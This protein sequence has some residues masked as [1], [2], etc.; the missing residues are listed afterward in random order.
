M[1]A[2]GVTM[3]ETVV[4]VVAMADVEEVVVMEE[5]EVADGDCLYWATKGEGR[6]SQT[7]RGLGVFGAIPT[8]GMTARRWDWLFDVYIFPPLTIE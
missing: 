2:E 8:R 4:A 1:A 5:G 7:K 6:A 3:T